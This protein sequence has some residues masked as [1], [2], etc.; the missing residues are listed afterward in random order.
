MFN[1]FKVSKFFLLFP[2]LGIF[3]VTTSTLFPFIV[4]K[5]VWFRS[6]VD[7]ALILFL[8][9]LLFYDNQSLMWNRVKFV[10]K[11]PL[12]IAVSLFVFIFLLAGFFGVDPKMSFWSNFERG[13]GGLQL[14]HFWIWFTLLATLFKE[15]KDWQ[16][17]FGFSL[18]GGLLM[19]LYGYL[20]NAE[21]GGYI[22][23]KFSQ[24]G[25]RF[26]G[27]IGN[28]AYAAAYAIFMLFYAG[29]ILVSKYRTRLSSFGAIVLY[30]VSA[31]SLITFYM[32]ATRGAFVG[33]IASL[34]V[35]IG[36]IVFS[37]ERLRKWGI[38]AMIALLLI[39]GTFIK[40]KDTPFIKSL[41]GSRIFDIS[42][43]A[44]TFEHR[45]YMW[46]TAIEGFKDRPLLG[47]GPENYI[48]VFE[49]HMDLNYFKPSEG[50]G[51]WFDR[52]HSI[53]F[54][55]LV[56]TGALGLV[57][58]LGI[59]VVFYMQFWKKRKNNSVLS[60]KSILEQTLIFSILVAYLVQGIVLFDVSPIYLNVFL[61]LAFGV[62]QFQ[63]P[64]LNNG[65]RTK[66]K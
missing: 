2:V 25:Y 30:L 48:R 19:I 66:N 8:L 4:G 58:F 18:V 16:K 55:Y 20:A 37:K 51:A 17:L 40:L 57:S 6:T 39:V 9:G 36:Y 22:G 3:I 33:L 54:D 31:I 35:G 52:A 27:S 23:G 56:E 63:S 32:A 44:E 1:Y 62:Y 24:P 50:F 53:Y 21:I 43:T 61:V 13:E 14:I 41:P 42:I 7:I 45:T 28:S 60:S 11:Q 59:F 38:G 49:R 29:Y 46:H 34:L 64:E 10:L 15:E 47:W 5:Y 65:T 12:V 26:S